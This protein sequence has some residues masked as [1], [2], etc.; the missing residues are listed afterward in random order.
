MVSAFFFCMELK[1]F[2]IIVNISIYDDVL[3]CA[4]CSFYL[5]TPLYL[6][7]D[8]LLLLLFLIFLHFFPLLI[9]I[10]VISYIDLD[11]LAVITYCFLPAATALS[12]SMSNAKYIN[13]NKTGV[14]FQLIYFCFFRDIFPQSQQSANICCDHFIYSRVCV[15]KS[16]P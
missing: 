10:V 14:S 12:L 13:S 2:A 9:S 8:L 1:R 6:F 15:I 16:Y 4:G 3:T 11:D 5:Y 7:P